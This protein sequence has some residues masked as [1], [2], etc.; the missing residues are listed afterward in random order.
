MMLRKID[1]NLGFG[2]QAVDPGPPQLPTDIEAPLLPDAVLH[3]TMLPKNWPICIPIVRHRIFL[4]IPLVYQRFTKMAYIGWYLH[5]SA[6]CTNLI[7]MIIS[8]ASGLTTFVNVLWAI[9]MLLGIPVAFIV[10]FLLYSAFKRE[11]TWMMV[12]WFFCYSCQIV[13]QIICAVGFKDGGAGAYMVYDADQAGKKILAI[14]LA[15]SLI[16]WIIVIIYSIVLIIRAGSVEYKI[17]GGNRAA[18][19]SA[20]E[21]AV[22]VARDNQEY[23]RQLANDNRDQIRQ[24]AVDNREAIG[25]VAYENRRTLYDVG[26]EVLDNPGPHQH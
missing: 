8:A 15:V 19:A 21:T 18:L 2:Q 13:Y 23:L 6:I 4:D 1:R 24:Y 9:L 22:D 5:S 7:A 14:V 11:K 3:D 20:G 25:Q 16:I 12:L 10:Y 26:R 17:M